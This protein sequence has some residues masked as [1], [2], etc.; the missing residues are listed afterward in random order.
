MEV[1]SCMD[2]VGFLKK[3]LIAWGLGFLFA[4]VLMERWRRMGGAEAEQSAA[5]ASQ[6]SAQT[7]AAAEQVVTA[8]STIDKVRHF[9][10][11]YATSLANGVKAD[12][13]WVKETAQRVA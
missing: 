3:L 4:F 7:E 12:V 11:N 13:R 2:D 9:G 1:K 6:P 10:A 8:G 5:V